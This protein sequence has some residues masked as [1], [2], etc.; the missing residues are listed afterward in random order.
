MGSEELKAATS[1]Q[2]KNFT[3]LKEGL[4]VHDTD[5]NVVDKDDMRILEQQW[6]VLSER[7]ASASEAVTTMMKDLRA[8]MAAF[9]VDN[10]DVTDIS[11][12][13]ANGLIKEMETFQQNISNLQEWAKTHISWAYNIQRTE[14]WWGKST[15][16]EWAVG[17]ENFVAGATV[18]TGNVDRTVSVTATAGT[19]QATYTTR[20]D[21]GTWM[22]TSTVSVRGWNGNLLNRTRNWWVQG[23]RP[24][25]RG[26]PEQQNPTPD[27]WAIDNQTP[28]E[29]PK[30][31]PEI[32]LDE[33]KPESPH[34]NT[35]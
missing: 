22:K 20:T 26:N 13:L 35:G 34:A 30:V 15:T 16:V 7:L 8:R 19:H 33:T 31:V 5:N 12:T 24:D 1:E 21:L 9:V 25:N 29:E 28:P 10:W 2:T 27:E 11:F 3:A 18:T 23:P 14:T 32:P 17:N 6:V 4:D